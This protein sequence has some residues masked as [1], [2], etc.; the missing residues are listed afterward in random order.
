M[1]KSKTTIHHP[2][3][4]G[5]MRQ[6]DLAPP[7][8][9]VTQQPAGAGN[10]QGLAEVA[11]LTRLGDY[12]FTCAVPAALADVG[13][14][15]VS[16]MFGIPLDGPFGGMAVARMLLLLIGG[17]ALVLVIYTSICSSDFKGNDWWRP[18]L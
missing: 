15:A 3:A 14:L 8:V 9:I 1:S 13:V 17:L 18:A 7:L 10:G 16:T 4:P 2:P 6:D 5:D 11:N 12:I